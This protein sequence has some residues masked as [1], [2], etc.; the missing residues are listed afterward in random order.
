MNTPSSNSSLR[1]L[2]LALWAASL[3]ASG[4][5]TACAADKPAPFAV[6]KEV[7]AVLTAHCAE[8]HSERGKGNVD[9]TSLEKLKLADRLEML[10]RIQDQLFFKM[11]PPQSADQ[12]GEREARVLAEW[13]RGELRQHKAS[14]LDDR[15]PYPDAGNYVDHAA[16]F[17]GSNKEKPSTPARRWLVSPQIFEERVLD[18]FQLEGRDRDQMRRSGFHGV[19]N[20]FLLPDH[21]GV[22]YYD[23]TPLDGSHLLVMLNN[24][25]WISS[26]QLQ[27]LR[28]KAGDSKAIPA[29]P[30][31]KWTPKITPPAF[32]A[33]VAK[34]AAPSDDE[35]RAAVQT[36]FR[37]VLRREPTPAELD[38]Y[39]NLGRKA[40]KVAGN[41]EGLRQVLKA[42][43]L[44][45]EFVYRYEF[46]AG[47]PDQYG[48]VP[49]APREAAYALA[50]A[51]GDRAPD[52][53]LLKAAEGGKLATKAD[54]EREVRRM[55]ADENYFR[56]QVDKS[57][58]GMHI[59]SHVTSHPK[60][61]R[62]FREFFGYPAAPKIFKDIP[63]S[64]G[65]YQN[66]DRGHLG[67]AGWMVHEA[68]E[69]V[70]WQVD[71]DRNVFERLLT[72]DQYFVY[73]NMDTKAGKA[74]IAEWKKVYETLKDTPWK[75]KPEEVMAQH[76]K[77]LL[78]AKILDARTKPTEMWREKRSFLSYMY[79]FQDTFGQGRT[80][81]TRGPFTHGYHYEHSPSYS[82]P[83]TPYRTRY[84]G[85]ETPR[86]KEPKDSPEYW[87]YPVEQ[88]FQ[89]PNRKG[90]LTHPAWLI[91]FSANTASDP[92]RRGKWIREKLLAGVVP[93]VPI[94]VDAKVP[95][96]PH[97]TLRE[98]VSSVTKAAA[99]IKCHS[100]MNDLGYPLEQFD[101]FGRFRTQEKLEHPDNLIKAGNGKTTFDIYKTKPLDPRGVLS[102]T[103]DPK[104]DGEVKD[105][106]DLIDRLA[107][108]DRV[109][110]SII[111]HAFRFFMG[112]NERP[113][114][115]QTL[116]DA[117]RAYI[118]SGGSFKAV[119]VSL[120]TSDS[121]IY[122]KPSENGL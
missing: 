44:E 58:N 66:A 32:E 23:L 73:H 120:L 67:S 114:D 56:G 116:I 27:V 106:F 118:Q 5:A 72:S 89:V 59:N 76:Q 101:D 117:D 70:I 39:L 110:Q 108:S 4:A 54:Y 68:D 104:L 111:R 16:L 119:V 18:V 19:T 84:V 105:S 13:V 15:L 41:G 34:K 2:S 7:G 63:R 57:L 33:I 47:K 43:L 21:A 14:K 80:P 24:A 112:R 78:A 92:I 8:C 30:K 36:Q 50:Y 93:D 96:D 61:I 49:L 53:Q 99:C 11:M 3:L 65:Y 60:L 26:K 109:R 88:P 28:V 98:R 113:S 69:F 77:L 87:D 1:S 121:F 17:D 55:L 25:E 82:L 91:A 85:V 94:T 75:T 115:S 48:R 97:K 100:R 52:A 45:S 81:F 29:D 38:L 9:V 6:P 42:V 64:G 12:P 74:L 46:G 107:K 95:D 102:G 103:G 86:Y 40:I 35:L 10:N 71:Q 37:L 51:L 83:P 79:W 90:I 62:F 31:D 122:R 20:P 22:R